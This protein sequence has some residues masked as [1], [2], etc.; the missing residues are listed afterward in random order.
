MKSVIKLIFILCVFYFHLLKRILLGFFKEYT[1]EL[2]RIAK[3][4]KPREAV[5]LVGQ[6]QTTSAIPPDQ[7]KLK[8]NTI[9]HSAAPQ[10]SSN[11]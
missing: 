1:P 7:S 3:E 5:T 10:T 9:I 4:P 2:R 6:K 8:N 11:K